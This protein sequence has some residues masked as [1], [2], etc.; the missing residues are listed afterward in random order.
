ML[1][2]EHRL[3]LTPLLLPG[4][5]KGPGDEVGKHSQFLFCELYSK[6]REEKERSRGWVLRFVSYTA[7]Q[8]SYSNPP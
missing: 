3:F 2:A 7:K 6:V 1:E 8:Y 5:E 4:E